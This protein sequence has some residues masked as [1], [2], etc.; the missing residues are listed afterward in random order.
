MKELFQTYKP[1]NQQLPNYISYYYFHQSLDKNLEREFVY[2]PHYKN[3]I[4]IYKDAKAERTNI[5]SKYSYQKGN[6][7][8]YYSSNTKDEKVRCLQGSFD[9]IGIVFQPLGLN[10]FLDVD[11]TSISDK[12]EFDFLYFGEEFDKVIEQV[13]SIECFN[14]KVSLLDDFFIKRL[15]NKLDFRIVKAVDYIINSKGIISTQQI[16]DSLSISRKTLLRLFYKHLNCSVKEYKNLVRFRVALNHY[17][18][19]QIKP[20]L[21]DIAY[22]NLFYDQANFINHFKKMVGKPPKTFFN[23]IEKVG[24]EDTYWTISE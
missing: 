7:E 8:I 5:K 4:T 18:A 17:Q 9:K 20:K 12:C 15:Q 23:S 13:Y 11:L 22:D 16:S 24:K 10:H 21:S 6:T 14:K 3:T 2:Y 19:Q 1:L